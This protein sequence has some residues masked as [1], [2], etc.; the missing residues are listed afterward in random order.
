YVVSLGSQVDCDPEKLKDKLAG[1]KGFVAMATH[2]GP[3][4]QA[5]HIALPAA[6]WC[7]TAG[8]YVNGKG[9]AQ[10]ADKVL[11]PR[12]DAHPGWQLVVSLARALGYDLGWKRR[13][14][15][16]AAMSGQADGADSAH[17]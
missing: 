11:V 3:L 15:V 2:D 6:A 12:G 1:V 7:E 16:K 10:T 14:D 4:A 17:E 9:I 5:A 8:T 13:A